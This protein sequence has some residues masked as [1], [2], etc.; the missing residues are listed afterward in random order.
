LNDTTYNR[1]DQG[2]AVHQWLVTLVPIG[3]PGCGLDVTPE[4]NAEAGTSK[5]PEACR[6]R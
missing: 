1:V 5:L 2:T 3:A 6:A 4:R